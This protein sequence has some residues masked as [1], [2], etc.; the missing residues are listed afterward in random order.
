MRHQPD[1]K[2]SEPERSTFVT[3]AA[4]SGNLQVEKVFQKNGKKYG[5]I[6]VKGGETI[7]HYAHWLRSSAHYI[8]KI[9]KIPFHKHIKMN[10]SLVIPLF[11][12]DESEFEEKRYEYHKEIEDDFADAYEIERLRVHEI[13]IGETVWTLCHSVFELPLW[14]VKKYNSD[15]NFGDLKPGQKLIVPIVRKKA[16]I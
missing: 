9:N 1:Q 13:K 4:T 12:I 16:S 14:L 15:L 11:Y 6:T 7:G 2:R 8:R 10:Y 3:Q 5:V